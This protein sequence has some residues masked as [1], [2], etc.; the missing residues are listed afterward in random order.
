M[1]LSQ[2]PLSELPPKRPPNPLPPHPPQQESKRIIQMMELHPHPLFALLTP[3][4]QPVAVKS[5]MLL[6]PKIYFVLWFII[7][8]RLV[9][10]SAILK[11]IKSNDIPLKNNYSYAKI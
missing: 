11:N 9:C 3:H 5:L 7:C 2:H 1:R 10:G 8:G 6:P 4:P